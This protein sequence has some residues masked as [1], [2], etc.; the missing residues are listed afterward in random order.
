MISPVLHIARFQELPDKPD[1]MLVLNAPAQNVDQ[2]MMV[3]VVKAPLDVS[4]NEPLDPCK[5]L[6]YILEYDLEHLR[7]GQ[8]PWDV[9]KKVGS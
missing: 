2:H 3:N 9:F 6:L 8:N 5:I 4:L 1:E 7:L